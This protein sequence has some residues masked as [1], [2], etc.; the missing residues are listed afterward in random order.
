M[1]LE[2]TIHIRYYAHIPNEY[3]KILGCFCK[4]PKYSQECVKTDKILVL[5]DSSYI[6]TLKMKRLILELLKESYP[7][8]QSA[9]LYFITNTPTQYGNKLPFRGTTIL[10]ED[11]EWILVNG[12]STIS[13]APC[14]NVWVY[15]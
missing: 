14:M 1:S 10:H 4:V 5:P 13:L 6:T 11:N 7:N 3:D 2:W 9:N 15:E 12:Y 8:F